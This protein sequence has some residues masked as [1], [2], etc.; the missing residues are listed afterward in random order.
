MTDSAIMIKSA[1]IKYQR[2]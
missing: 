2:K 1:A